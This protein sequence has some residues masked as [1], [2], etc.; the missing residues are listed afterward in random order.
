MSQARISIPLD[1]PDV[2]VLTAHTN[3]DGELII[4]VEST[5]DSAR[6]LKCGRVIRKFH[7][8][9]GWVTLRHLAILGQP[10]LV[11]YRPKRYQCL[12]CDRHPTSTQR[13]SWHAPNSPNT[14]AYETHILLQLVNATVEDV[15]L[16]EC[17]GYDTVEGI[18]DRH[19]A[20]QVDWTRF[21][22]LGV[23]GMDEIALKKGHRDFVVIVTARL[24]EHRLALLAV[25]PDREKPTVL[26]FLRSIPER[27]RRT[28]HT[29][30]CDMY[31]AYVNAAK[32]V[33]P[34][35]QI[36]IDRFHVA[37]QY[38]EAA[39]GLRKQE[40]KRLK[41]ELPASEFKEL[42]GHLWAFRK[43]Q[44]DR[45]AQEQAVL[46]H[47][48]SHA[49]QLALAYAFREELTAIFELRIAKSAAQVKLRDWQARVRQSGLK[50]FDSF[51]TTLEN[52]WEEITDY[53]VHRLNSGFV[54]GLNNKLKVLKRRCYGL[55][56]LDHL[57]QRIFLD[58]EGYRQFV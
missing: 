40:L 18:I 10:V 7:G 44:A 2:R 4:S 43:N 48:F 20:A 34:D 3:S 24:A 35:A 6:C 53:F 1:L 16:K 14:R 36:V 23:L 11:R 22:S 33:L 30:C 42:K 31:P 5:L 52:W 39:D 25:L 27:L 9:D 58:L 13:V 26:K 28:I 47:L 57:F 32:E 38:R 8:H 37:E 54:E 51:L 41:Q 45:S 15:S 21:T 49:P 50:C 55:F 17:L 19:I 12:E 46:A 29:V 56:N